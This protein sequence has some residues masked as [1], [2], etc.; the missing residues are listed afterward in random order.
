MQGPHK[1]IKGESM[2]QPQPQPQP[3][4]QLKRGAPRKYEPKICPMCKKEYGATYLRY[5][6]MFCEKKEE[7]RG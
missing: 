7:V 1:K 5:H 2:T 6:L 4:Q 3:Q